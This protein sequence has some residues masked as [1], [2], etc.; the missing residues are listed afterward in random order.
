MPTR[1][2][3][4]RSSQMGISKGHTHHGTHLTWTRMMIT[5]THTPRGVNLQA[6]LLQIRQLNR[7]LP[8][9]RRRVSH[10]SSFHE[11]L[12]NLQR[13]R[14]RQQTY[15]QTYCQAITSHHPTSMAD[16]STSLFHEEGSQ[17]E[18]EPRAKVEAKRGI[19]SPP[20]APPK[21]PMAS[22]RGAA[23]S[24]AFSSHSTGPTHTRTGPRQFWSAVAVVAP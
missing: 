7:H 11:I 5:Q 14:N 16:E 18:V 15:F 6:A 8:N 1:Y 20:S 21:L 22:D 10:E 13:A 24:L 2:G 4:E 23:S 12:I 3:H 19:S 17:A 9:P